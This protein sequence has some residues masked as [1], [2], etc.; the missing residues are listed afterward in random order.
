MGN[1]E[2][3][4]QFSLTL[5]A[6]PEVQQA[7]LDLQDNHGADVNLV[8][9]LLYQGSLGRQLAQETIQTIVQE[10][11]S[12]RERVIQPIRALRKSLKSK[13]YSLEHGEDS[14]YQQMLSLELSAEKLAQT[15]LQCINFTADNDQPTAQAAEKNLYA[16][17]KLLNIQKPNTAIKTLLSC[18]ES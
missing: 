11:C 14:L 18:M 17:A 2:S 7:C 4:W 3:L 8:L 5:Y 13:K 6:A 9:F 10:T 15:H 1:G 16:Y 12:F